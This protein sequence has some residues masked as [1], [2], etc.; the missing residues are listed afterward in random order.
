[1][2]ILNFYE[3]SLNESLPREES[4]KQLKK[5]VKMT[6]KTDIG[7]KLEKSKNIGNVKNPIDDVESYEDFIKSQKK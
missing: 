1:M 6:K 4:V 2:K 7:N 5:I 3:Y